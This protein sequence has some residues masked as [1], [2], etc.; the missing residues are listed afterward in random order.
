MGGAENRFFVTRSRV[1]PTHPR[2]QTEHQIPTAERYELSTVRSQLALVASLINFTLALCRLL[3]LT[4]RIVQHIF[5]STG[6]VGSCD[7]RASDVLCL[8]LLLTA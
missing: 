3:I 7:E 2:F 5:R 4:D 8:Q 1:C 6:R